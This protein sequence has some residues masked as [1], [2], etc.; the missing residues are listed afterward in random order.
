MA[1]YN[2]R[3]EFI[4]KLDFNFN[5]TPQWRQNGEKSTTEMLLDIIKFYENYQKLSQVEKDFCEKRFVKL[6]T[7]KFVLNVNVGESVGTQTMDG[8]QA[9]LEAYIENQAESNR[10]PSGTDTAN[11]PRLVT[12]NV[13]KALDEFFKLRDEMKKTGKL[14]V[15]QICDIHRILMDRLWKDA[16]E[17][18]KAPAFT[19][20]N[21]ED[22][23]YPDP[24]AVETI[25]YAC[26]D[27]HCA[28]M[29]YYNKVL[30]NKVPSVETFAYLFKC[31]ARLL[32]DFVDTHPFGDGNGRMC[33]L[34]AN[35]VLSLITPFP[36]VLY[37]TGEG[38]GRQDYMNA[39][40]ECRD[41]RDKGPGTLASMLIEG[42]WRGWKNLFRILERENFTTSKVVGPV[43]VMKSDDK[44]TRNDKVI[45]ALKQAN[46]A[47]SDN[48]RV[49]GCVT[50]AIDEAHV[51][52]DV[53]V[54]KIV[55]IL[56]V[57]L[58]L[59]IYN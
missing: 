45:R 6:M 56:D 24:I 8:T 32:F 33:R 9:V 49:L 11:D 37:S 54:R 44:Q 3:Y 48:P 4:G 22:Y 43:V 14:T 28:H 42:T 1:N 30:A 59:H 18:R 23:F 12:I 2:N 19:E 58:H 5:E 21:S 31:A 34:L 13:Y 17:I 39:I 41:H 7:V 53:A 57:D 36:V 51:S 52:D 25:F 26:I 40:V 15:Q 38:S 10:P 55:Q 35:Y 50:N 20:W 29:T 47:E 46:I 27:H 16:G